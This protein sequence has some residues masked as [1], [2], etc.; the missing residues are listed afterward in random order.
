MYMFIGHSNLFG[1]NQTLVIFLRLT[2]DDYN[3]QGLMLDWDELTLS[4]SSVARGGAEG[5][6]PPPIFQPD[7]VCRYIHN[8]CRYSE[9]VDRGFSFRL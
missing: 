4:S 2:P 3:H 7:Q 6:C 8:I 9:F 5:N 1:P